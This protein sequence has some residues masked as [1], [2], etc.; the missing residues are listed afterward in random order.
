MKA[1]R[2]VIASNKVP[3]LQMRSLGLHNTPG[4]KKET[5]MER[6]GRYLFVFLRTWSHRLRPKKLHA[7]VAVPPAPV[8]VPSQ[9]PLSPGAHCHSVDSSGY[10]P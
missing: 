3:Y 1:V 8:R 10:F 5:K 2:P 7:S 6:E 4:R 9:R